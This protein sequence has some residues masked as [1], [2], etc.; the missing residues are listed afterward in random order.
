M[1]FVQPTTVFIE[2]FQSSGVA[3]VQVTEQSI[4]DPVH[5]FFWAWLCLSAEALLGEC[6][7]SLVAFT[8]ALADYRTNEI[9]TKNLSICLECDIDTP[10]GSTGLQPSHST[11]EVMR[12]FL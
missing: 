10:L 11:H 1:S 5:V 12:S 8:P 7:S 9:Q 3:A 6:G 4:G 2:W